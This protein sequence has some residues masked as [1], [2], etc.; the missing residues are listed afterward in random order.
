MEKAD[1]DDPAET[2]LAGGLQ[3]L[4]NRSERQESKMRERKGLERT[5]MYAK[6]SSG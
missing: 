5:W 6:I 1:R 2:D 4:A 3:R